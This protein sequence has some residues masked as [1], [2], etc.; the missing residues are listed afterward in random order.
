MLKGK[1]LSIRE[2][3]EPM[4]LLDGDSL[5]LYSDNIDITI[6]MYKARVIVGWYI[7]EI[8]KVLYVGIKDA[9]TGLPIHYQQD[10]ELYRVPGMQEPDVPTRWEEW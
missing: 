5:R 10:E 3:T 2:L 6:P 8:D 4:F 9:R 1:I 7:Y